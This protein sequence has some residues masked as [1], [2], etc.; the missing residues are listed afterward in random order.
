MRQDSTN[1]Q[2]ERNSSFT[3]AYLTFN[4]SFGCIC[5]FLEFYSNFLCCKPQWEQQQSENQSPSPAF[6]SLLSLCNPVLQITLHHSCVHFAFQDMKTPER[7]AS[8]SFFLICHLQLSSNVWSRHQRRS[9]L[10]K[11]ISKLDFLWVFL[12]AVL[13]DNMKNPKFPPNTTD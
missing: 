7:L 10:G 1:N 6:L 11:T 13:Q 4:L 8:A 9:F 3:S 12:A 5:I 2:S